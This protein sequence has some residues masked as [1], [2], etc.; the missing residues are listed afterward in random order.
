MKPFKDEKRNYVSVWNRRK[1][2][3]SLQIYSRKRVSAF[4]IDETIIQYKLV[5]NISGCGLY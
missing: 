1:R 4:I 5:V 2:I 3:G